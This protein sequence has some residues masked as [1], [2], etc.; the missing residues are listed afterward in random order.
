MIS[1]SFTLIILV[2]LLLEELLQLISGILDRRALERD[3]PPGLQD[4]YDPDQYRKSQDYKR[5]TTRFAL[6]RGGCD[7]LALLLFWFLGGFP[8]VEESARTIAGAQ[9]ITRGLLF[10]AILLLLRT[11]LALPFRLYGT[12]VLE[13][14]YGFNRTTPRTFLLDH[15]KGLL[16][17]LLLGAPLGAGVIAF[18]A[19]AGQWAWLYCWG[20]VTLYTLCLQYIGPAWIM[21]DRKSVV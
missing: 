12:F 6:I 20:A 11:M 4:L 15:L 7:L 9:P 21:P 18:F 2:A 16:L 3:P 14:R 19:Y 10:F 5:A 8:W 13:A 17:T 1:N